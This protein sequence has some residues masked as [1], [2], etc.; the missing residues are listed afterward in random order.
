MIVMIVN[1]IICDRRQGLLV[2]ASGGKCVVM[3]KLVSMPIP[4][5]RRLSL[6]ATR[7]LQEIYEEEFGKSISDGEAQILGVELIKFFALLTKSDS[8]NTTPSR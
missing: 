2:K 5:Q 8:S 7:H 1:V 3:I 6:E 4:V